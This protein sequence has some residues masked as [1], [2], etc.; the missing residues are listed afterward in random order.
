MEKKHLSTLVRKFTESSEVVKKTLEDG[1]TVLNAEEAATSF[2]ANRP[3][4]PDAHL[5]RKIICAL[6]AEPGS[7]KSF[8]F[9]GLLLRGL[10]PP[11][12]LKEFALL[13]PSENRNAMNTDGVTRLPIRAVYCA[14]DVCAYLKQAGDGDPE[15]VLESFQGPQFSPEEDQ[16]FITREQLMTLSATL[17]TWNNRSDIKETTYIELQLPSRS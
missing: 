15:E 6:F 9:N 10:V 1:K 8:V 13:G 17:K 12:E 5:D 11:E 4:L 3:L 16:R 7:G 14:S 2:V